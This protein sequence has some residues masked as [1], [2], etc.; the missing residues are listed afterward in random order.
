MNKL[1]PTMN[2]LVQKMVARQ[3]TTTGKSLAVVR[4]ASKDCA[5]ED[6]I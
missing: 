1:L 4:C 5:K 3:A 2:L 6:C